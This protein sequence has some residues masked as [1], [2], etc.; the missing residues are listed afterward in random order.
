M[1]RFR[2]ILWIAVGAL[3]LLAQTPTRVRTPRFPMRAD[4]A[5]MAVKQ[6]AEQLADEKKGFERDVAVLRHLRTADAAL[7]DS[8]QPENSLQKAFE[9]VTA[10]KSLGPDFLVAQGVIRVHHELENA[11]RSPGATDFGHLRTVLRSEA[12]VPASRVMVRNALRL[13]EE[14]LSWLKVQQLIAEHLRTLSEISSTSLRAS[15]EER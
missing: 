5:E 3:P 14:T 13:E 4:M 6:A 1:G 15:E 2:L 7:A 10:A 11:R 12:L 9:E 8:M